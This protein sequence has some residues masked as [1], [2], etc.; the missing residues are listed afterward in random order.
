MAITAM[1]GLVPEWFEPEQEE[2]DV[3]TRFKLKPLN[4]MEYLEVI[5]YIRGQY[6]IGDGVKLAL[7]YGLV[8]W[9]NVFGEDGKA[10]KFSRSGVALLPPKILSMLSAE[11]IE[12]SSF[13]GEKAKN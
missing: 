8:D 2:S 3:K 12:R 6:L 1:T 10:V 11:I 4:G 13:D 7:G 9:E 5:P